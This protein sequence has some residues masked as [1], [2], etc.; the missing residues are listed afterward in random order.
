[1]CILLPSQLHIYL[2]YTLAFKYTVSLEESS[3]KSAMHDWFRYY[4]EEMIMYIQLWN[5]AS[6]MQ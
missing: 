3:V 1:M 2:L 5:H 6:C 4:Y